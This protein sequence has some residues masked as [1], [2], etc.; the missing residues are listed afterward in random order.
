VV[1]YPGEAG[2]AAQQVQRKELHFHRVG[3]G[4]VPLGKAAG[5]GGEGTGSLPH[6]ISAAFLA[7]RSCLGSVLHWVQAWK[8]CLEYLRVR[9]NCGT[10]SPVEAT[11]QGNQTMPRYTR[12]PKFG[13]RPWVAPETHSLS[14]V[15]R[16]YHYNTPTSAINSS[17]STTNNNMT[18][19]AG[20]G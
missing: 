11:F 8:I 17:S 6:A 18:G 1:A 5:G 13:L 12:R 9:L 7:A 2:D 19:Q 3:R 10:P 20:Q 4:S 16:R 15:G 14:L